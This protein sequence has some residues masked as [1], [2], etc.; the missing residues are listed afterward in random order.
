MLVSIMVRFAV[1]SIMR[2]F[3]SDFRIVFFEDDN[4]T[5]R[6]AK[7]TGTFE[8]STLKWLYVKY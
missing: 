3:Y 8:I 1:E 2:L 4:N 6:I 5:F 7:L